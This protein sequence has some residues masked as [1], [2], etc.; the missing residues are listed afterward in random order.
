MSMSMHTQVDDEDRDF[1]RSRRGESGESGPPKRSVTS[2]SSSGLGRK[3]GGS[4]ETGQPTVRCV[5]APSPPP[6]HPSLVVNLR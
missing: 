1:R 5:L 4:Q 2:G 3:R 6:P